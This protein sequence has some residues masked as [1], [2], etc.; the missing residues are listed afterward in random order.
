MNNTG[1]CGSF[2]ILLD[3]STQITIISFPRLVELIEDEQFKRELAY[4]FFTCSNTSS[5]QPIAAGIFSS[6]H[7]IAI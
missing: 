5:P 3:Q 1:N 7:L 2:P 6:A 4:I